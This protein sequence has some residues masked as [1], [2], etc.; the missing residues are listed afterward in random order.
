MGYVL[1]GAEASQFSGKARAYLRWKG[2]D[3]SEQTA[4]PE[5]YRDLVEPRIG[6]AV[7][8]ILITPDG[9]AVQDSADIIDHVERAEAGPS[10]FPD[11]PVQKLA[12]LLLE[13]YADEW[14][15]IPAM[16]YRW[17]YNEPWIIEEFGRNAAP[18]A[19]PEEQ[20]RIGQVIATTV[21]ESIPRVGVSEETISGIEAHYEGFLADYSAHLRKMPFAFG[22]RP[23][24]ADFALFGPL[25]GPLYRDPASGDLMRRLAPVVADW[26]ERMLAAKADSKALLPNDETPASLYPIFK[27]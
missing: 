4:T 18:N 14:L 25:Y 13:L 1:I 8:P 11:G 15:I 9:E 24:L 7:I 16:H 5:V 2:I 17:S 3:F 12:S 22:D 6:F 10:V 20:R 19:S 21:K 23:S 27:R 26:V